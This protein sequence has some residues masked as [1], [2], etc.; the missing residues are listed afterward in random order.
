[1]ISST[2]NVADSCAVNHIHLITNRLDLS[3]EE[4]LSTYKNRW[5]IVLFCKWIKQHLKVSYLFSQSPVD[6]WNQMFTTMIIYAL[7]EIMRL[8]HQ[9]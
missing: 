6:I 3:E 4:I 5:Y 1:M 7:V 2:G 9:P 8:I